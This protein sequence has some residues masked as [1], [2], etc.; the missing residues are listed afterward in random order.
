MSLSLFCREIKLTLPELTL[1]GSS[2][3][4]K[5]LADMELP[6][7]LGKGA[8]LS[9]ISDT[10]LTVVKVQYTSLVLKKYAFCSVTASLTA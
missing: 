5:L 1:E 9:K 4:Q 3:L 8:D 7:L 2:D 6:A 10:N